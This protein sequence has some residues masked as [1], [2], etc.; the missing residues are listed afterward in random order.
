MHTEKA[1]RFVLLQAGDGGSRNGM[2][3]VKRHKLPVIVSTRHVMCHVINV[4]NTA[5][6]YTSKFREQSRSTGENILLSIS[7]TLRLCG[8]MDVQY[9]CC[10]NH[11]LM[12][13]RQSIMLYTLNSCSIRC[14]LH[15]QHLNKTARK[16]QHIR[17]QNIL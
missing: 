11:S 17:V 14:Q 4:M 15:S 8:M 7:L 9:I 1:I 3:A 16:K 13:V 6:W 10:D 12:P 2:K 5:V